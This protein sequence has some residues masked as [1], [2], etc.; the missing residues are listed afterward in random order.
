MAGAGAKAKPCPP[1]QPD[2]AARFPSFA[3]RRWITARDGTCRA[4]GCTAPARSCDVDHTIDHANGGK[5]RHDN[6]G[7][8]CRHHHRLKHEGGFHLDQPT[9]GHF[10]WRAPSGKTYISDPDPPW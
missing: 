10:I 6:I 8:L 3:L 5:T 1:T 7:L 9:P 2:E 4:P